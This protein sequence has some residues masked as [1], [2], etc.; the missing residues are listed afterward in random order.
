MFELLNAKSFSKLINEGVSVD[1]L[2]KQSVEILKTIHSTELKPGELPS[3]KQESMKWV[4]FTKDYLPEEIGGKLLKMFEEIPETNTMLHGDFHVKNIMQQ[5]GENLLIDMDT[6]SMGHPIYEF[7]AIY[8]AYIGYSCI[9]KNNSA[10]FFNITTEQCFELW[11]ATK[12]YYFADKS[13]D[14]ITNIEKKSAIICYAR[15]FRWYST[16]KSKED[17]LAQQI[18]AYCKDYLIENVPLVDTLY[19]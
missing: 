7:A 14:Y 1:E 13:E 10:E 15:L 2:A 18:I 8:A 9:D 11:N 3:K 5:N 16:K 6:L 12:K 17:E 19:F 4:N